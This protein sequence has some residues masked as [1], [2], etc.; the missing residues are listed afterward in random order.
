MKGIDLFC[1]SSA[2]TAICSSMDQRSM[3]RNR[4]LGGNRRP[5]DHHQHRR[6]DSHGRSSVDSGSRR[7]RRKGSTRILTSTTSITHPVSTNNNPKHNHH[8]STSGNTRKTSTKPTIS[9]GHDN[10]LLD[11]SRYL[12]S[13]TTFLDDHQYSTEM[14]MPV[15]ASVPRRQRPSRSA[16]ALGHYLNEPQSSPPPSSRSRALVPLDEPSSV[17]STPGYN[18]EQPRLSSSSSRSRALVPRHHEEQ[19]RLS[20]SS[21][22]SRN[23]ALVPHHEPLPSPSRT[24]ALVRHEQSS[25]SLKS[26]ALVPR[27]H[28]DQFSSKTRSV[29]RF[30]ADSSPALLPAP[31]QVVVLRVSLHCKG[32]EAKV[33]KHVSRMEGVT[34]YNIDFANK[35]VTVT[36]DVTPLGVLTSVSKVKNAEFWPSTSST[37][38]SPTSN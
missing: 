31:H 33:R 36:G 4:H 12:L 22:S 25:S 35:K 19:P 24:R 8:H 29:N 37:T 26:Q 27:D 17:R 38:S 14:D 18:E 23:R 21:S 28:N 11:S 3:V 2:S 13:D 10:S 5:F 30:S 32:C 7:S 9:H 20:S 1:S 34:S 16:H 6:G 15:S